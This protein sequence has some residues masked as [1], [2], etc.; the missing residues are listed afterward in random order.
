[1]RLGFFQGEAAGKSFSR[2]YPVQAKRD[3]GTRTYRRKNA[4]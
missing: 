4:H 2:I 3:K 1:M